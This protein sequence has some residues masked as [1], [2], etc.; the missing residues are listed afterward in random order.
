MNIE[1]HNANLYLSYDPKNEETKISLGP[2]S[3]KSVISAKLLIDGAVKDSGW[4]LFPFVCA[5]LNLKFTLK[6]CINARVRLVFP[7]NLR[8][9]IAHSFIR[10]GDKKYDFQA[11]D[12]NKLSHESKGLNYEQITYF[13]SDDSEAIDHTP[14]EIES[15]Y[16]LSSHRIILLLISPYVLGIPIIALW[17]FPYFNFLAKISLTLSVTPLIYYAWTN[18]SAYMRDII[19][20][21]SAFYVFLVLAWG[22]YIL[23][24]QLFESNTYIIIFITCT[25]LV[26]L[27]LVLRTF[28]QFRYCPIAEEKKT[29]I[30]WLDIFRKFCVWFYNVLDMLSKSAKKQFRR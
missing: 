8:G 10:I 30:I 26:L 17:F 23:L 19:C 25:Y 1:S 18:A 20:L 5:H 12:K 21:E 22:L 24:L 29:G 7:K 27:Y 4:N 14:I 11:H 2:K 3:S 16:R 15:Y 28:L 6:P 13:C 9:Y